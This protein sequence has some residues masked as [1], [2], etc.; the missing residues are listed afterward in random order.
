[1]TARKTR[2]EH[3]TQV[4]PGMSI[5]DTAAA[6]GISK[7]ELCR[8][9]RLAEVPQADFEAQVAAHHNEGVRLTA[10]SI[11]AR[12]EERLGIPVPARG[13]V[14]RAI[15]LCRNMTPAERA[16]FAARFDALNG[17]PDA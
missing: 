8:W 11:V 3:G 6:L 10:S 15:A 17:G 1:M 14:E 12:H 7:A 5:R 9:Q 16:A 13:R 2:P 4:T